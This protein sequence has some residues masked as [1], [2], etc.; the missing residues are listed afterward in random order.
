[1]PAFCLACCFLCS[2]VR[3]CVRACVRACARAR[4]IPPQAPFLYDACDAG[5]NR[6]LNDERSVS[7]EQRASMSA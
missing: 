7:T 6:C 5:L 2:G 3:V 1:M 4:G